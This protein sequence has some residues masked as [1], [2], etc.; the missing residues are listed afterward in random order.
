M[1][2]RADHFPRNP[3]RRCIVAL[4]GQ[5]P[6]DP[7]LEIE[8]ERIEW[9]ELDRSLK[10]LLRQL[11]LVSVERNPAVARPGPGI[12]GIKGQRAF[13]ESLR[14]LLGIQYPNLEVVVINDGSKDETLRVLQQQFGLSAVH[15]IY[16]HRLQTKPVRALYRST[17]H[18][19]L[20]VV[21]KDN[22]GKADSL[23]A[24]LN[25]ASNELVCAIDADTLIEP[26]ALQRMVRPFI[27]SDEIVAAGGSA[28]AAVV[29]ALDENAVQAHLQ[30]VVKRAGRIDVSF[31]AIG[32]Q[33]ANVVGV[34]LL[35]LDVEGFSAP[36]AAYTRSY[37]LTARQ[38]ARHMLPRKSGV[39]M[40]VTALLARMGTRLNGGYGASQAAKEALTRDL[41]AELSPHGI[42]VVVPPFKCCTDNAAMIAYA[43]SWRLAR[44]ENDG[45]AVTVSPRTALPQVTRKGRGRRALAK[46]AAG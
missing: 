45:L 46:T 5:R 38:A 23:N 42:R 2:V 10:P 16:Q 43:G 26:D 24:G 27:E 40:T 20:V 37:F 36:I 8:L 4:Q 22:G 3:G 1:G 35:E 9:T 30:A 29:D 14:A 25:I 7:Y 11:R 15:P 21:D 34:P 41:S 6:G 33:E 18:P 12:V 28:E 19:N 13:D 17:I 44:G 31:N 39:I 32:V